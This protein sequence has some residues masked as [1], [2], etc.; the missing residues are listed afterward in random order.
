VT[1][2]QIVQRFATAEGAEVYRGQWYYVFEGGC[3]LYE[4]DA[5]GAGAADLENIVEGTL[6]F[7]PLEQLREIARRD[8][9]EI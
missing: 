7:A 8:G 9:F 3:V 5:E 6:G 1:F 2:D 4:F